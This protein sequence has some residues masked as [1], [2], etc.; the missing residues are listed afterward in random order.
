MKTRPRTVP[1]FFVIISAFAAACALYAA[2]GPSV[3]KASAGPPPAPAEEWVPY[4][5][6]AA[7]TAVDVL[8]CGG[9]VFAKVKFTFNDGGYRVADWGQ[10]EKS[11]SNFTADVK[12]ERWTGVTIQVITFA[13]R[14]YDLGQLAPGPYTFTLNSRGA[15]V[16][17]RQFTVS[18]DGSL[19]PADDPAVFVWQHYRDFLGRDPD[20]QGFRFWTGGMTAGCGADA[21]C[22]ERKRVDTSA[23]F[24]LSIEFRQTGFFV[25]K[26]YRASY[27]RMPRREELLP[28]TRRIA[29]GVVVNTQGWEALLAERTRVF[30]DE[31]VTRPEFRAGFDQLSDSQFVERLYQNAGVAPDPNAGN[32]LAAAISEGRMT[33]AQALRAVVEEADFSRREFNPAFVLMQYFGYL[34]RNPDE[35]R[36]ANWDGY[37]FWLAKL[38]QFGGDYRRA[39]M[40]KAF[41]N[42]DEYRGRF[43]GQ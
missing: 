15:L 2:A 31:W 3:R 26:L 13:E 41:V 16:K 35:G 5:P 24:F 40:V 18:T 11:G 19:S 1:G 37:D 39:E 43:C 17:S 21:A 7:Q 20:D 36:D 27:G 8:T 6:N 32:S 30:L 42:S 25:H 28:D 4:T 29:R 23:A 12:V 38:N 34:G 14:V 33:R 22:L 9:R 10:A